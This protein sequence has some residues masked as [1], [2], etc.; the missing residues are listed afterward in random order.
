MDPLGKLPDTPKKKKSA[1]I[2]N[3]PARKPGTVT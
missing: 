2:P 3:D 1:E